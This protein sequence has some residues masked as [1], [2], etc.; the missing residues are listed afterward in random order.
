V[1]T[2]SR[3]L[4][5]P[6]LTDPPNVPLDIENL[7]QDVDAFVRHIE[8]GQVVITPS[9]A[10]TPTSV[11]VTFATPYAAAPAVMV[12][13]YSAVAGTQILGVGVTNIT[14]TG[15]TIWLTRTNTTPGTVGWL[16]V[17]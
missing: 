7:A 11:A 8:S 5:Y 6:A 15:C 13:A 12:S 10:N 2:T 14:T 17:G 4:R 16:A 9:A 1:A 3:G